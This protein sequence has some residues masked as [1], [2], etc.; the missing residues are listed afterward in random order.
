MNIK[1]KR[2]GLIVAGL[3]L[4]L[5]VCRCVFNYFDQYNQENNRKWNE[6]KIMNNILEKYGRFPIEYPLNYSVLQDPYYVVQPKQLQHTNDQKSY[7][8]PVSFKY[9][10]ITLCEPSNEN[11]LSRKIQQGLSTLEVETLV[12]VVQSIPNAAIIDIGA[13]VGMFL[14]PVLAAMDYKIKSIAVEANPNNMRMLMQGMVENKVP[15]NSCSLI[16]RAVADTVDET[17]SMAL[18]E[19]P[20]V[21][22]GGVLEK[23]NAIMMEKVST[24][25]VKTATL[26]SHIL[27][28]AKAMNIT[29]EL[30]NK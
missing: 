5:Y 2:V 9:A 23:S 1:F 10:T 13:N 11:H 18:R 6:E 19:D 24:V 12:R 8:L 7:C 26:D 29:K 21:T 30:D 17:V 14:F 15:H 20:S 28:V 27:K 3:L 25:K 4:L 22:N 16:H